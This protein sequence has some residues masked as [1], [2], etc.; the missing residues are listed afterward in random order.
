MIHTFSYL[1]ITLILNSSKAT[2]FNNTKP[3]EK[4]P[5]CICEEKMVTKTERFGNKFII[6]S[7]VFFFEIRTKNER[8]DKER[9]VYKIIK[10]VVSKRKEISCF[11]KKIEIDFFYSNRYGKIQEKSGFLDSKGFVTNDQEADWMHCQIIKK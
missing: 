1:I 8:N 6:P 9:N 7:D 11:E 10:F 3:F 4:S 2:V 5:P